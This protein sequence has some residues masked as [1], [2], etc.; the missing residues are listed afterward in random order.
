[1]TLRS[2]KLL[3]AVRELPCCWPLAHQC[4][5][6][7]EP[8][9]SNQIR[10]GHGKS[11]KAHDYRI[12]AICHGAHAEHDQGKDLQKAER[13]EAWDEAHRVTMGL[14]IERGILRVR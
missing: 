11:I 12:A 4:W 13:R 1:M 5:G 2:P 6:A 14:L 7:V 8:S 9:H 3:K 10:D